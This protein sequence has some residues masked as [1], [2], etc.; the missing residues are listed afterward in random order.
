[1]G[2]FSWDEYDPEAEAEAKI[3]EKERRE[4]IIQSYV[5]SNQYE[6]VDVALTEVEK[7]KDLFS[8]YVY[9]CLVYA[10]NN[11]QPQLIIKKEKEPTRSGG[12]SGYAY[13]CPHCKNSVKSNSH[14][15]KHCGQRLIPLKRIETKEVDIIDELIKR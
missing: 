13:S 7:N 14:I 4:K 5:N 3:K 9:K 12:F 15:C 10:L 6:W 8:D 1:M 2:I 11:R